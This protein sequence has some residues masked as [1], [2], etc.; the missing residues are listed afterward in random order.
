MYKMMSNFAKRTQMMKAHSQLFEEANRLIACGEK[1]QA[2]NL[3]SKI[4]EEDP[5]CKP[6]LMKRAVLEKEL[7][8]SDVLTKNCR[9]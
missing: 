1:K 3:I 8:L 6:A 9:P 4:L 2:S 5:G 7:N